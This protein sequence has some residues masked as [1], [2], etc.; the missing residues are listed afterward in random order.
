MGRKVTV[1]RWRGVARQRRR[2]VRGE[3]GWFL[4]QMTSS[5]WEKVTATGCT[6]APGRNPPDWNLG[7][8][9]LRRFQTDGT[10]L[11]GKVW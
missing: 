5:G 6:A 2:E 1:R 9:C 7:R 4:V 3:W 8:V 10:A 11:L